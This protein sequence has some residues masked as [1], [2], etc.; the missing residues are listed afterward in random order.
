MGFVDWMSTRP[1][2]PRESATCTLNSLM[3]WPP[4]TKP[5]YGITWNRRSSPFTSAFDVS[6][7]WIHGC[8]HCGMSV[9]IQKRYEIFGWSCMPRPTPGSSCTTLMPCGVMAPAGPTP[10]RSSTAGLW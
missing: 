10:E 7:A 1:V 2:R 5:T 3:R 6:S 8:G 9:P 4:S